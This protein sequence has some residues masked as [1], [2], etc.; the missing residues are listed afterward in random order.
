MDLHACKDTILYNP[1]IRILSQ[2]AK[3]ERYKKSSDLHGVPKNMS[4]KTV[5]L[6]MYK[7][8]QKRRSSYKKQIGKLMRLW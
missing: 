1:D 3:K 7:I 8:T 5:S 2:D 4:Y 6:N